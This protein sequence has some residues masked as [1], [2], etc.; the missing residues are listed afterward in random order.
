MSI[1]ERP[2]A[3]IHTP[4][5]HKVSSRRGSKKMAA[6]YWIEGKPYSVDDVAA[7]INLSRQQTIYRISSVRARLRERNQPALLTWAV[8][9]PKEKP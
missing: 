7:R 9:T 4:A 6:I 8:L 5:E 1:K 3:F 2:A